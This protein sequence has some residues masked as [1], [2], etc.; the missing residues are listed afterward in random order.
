[1]FNSQSLVNTLSYMRNIWD[2][3]NSDDYVLM[4]IL[5]I[6]SVLSCICACL[7]AFMKIFYLHYSDKLS[8]RN[9]LLS[10]DAE[11]GAV[12]YKILSGNLSTKFTLNTSSQIQA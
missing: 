11:T 12:H 1:M 4:R 7:S 9:V 2:V 3:Q 6:L 5:L 8:A 10:T